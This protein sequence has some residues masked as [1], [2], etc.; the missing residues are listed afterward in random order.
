MA[1]LRQIAI[2]AI[3]LASAVL[4]LIHLNMLAP[5]Q[6]LSG[7]AGNR[8]AKNQFFGMGL[9]NSAGCAQTYRDDL[10]IKAGNSVIRTEIARS[11]AAQEK[12]LGGRRCISE[13]EGMLFPFS[14]PGYYPFWMKDMRFPIDM[15]WLS[16]DKKV[17]YIQPDVSPATYP[18]TFVNAKPASYVLELKAGGAQDL[19]LQDG[20]QLSF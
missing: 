12:G 1:D 5:Y 17:V 2:S 10:N 18:K 15:L 4:S 8:I 16:A 3:I 9:S 11:A 14:R 20:S 19:G 13:D 6:N 7:A